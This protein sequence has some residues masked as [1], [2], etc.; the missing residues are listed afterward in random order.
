MIY[1]DPFPME[2]A[3]QKLQN[4]CGYQERCQKDV[5][6]KLIEIGVAQGYIDA[7]IDRLI[8]DDFL[9]EERFARAFVRGKFNIKK[10]GKIR[11][12]AELKK[13]QI[14]K[15]HLDL[16]LTQ[17][18]ETEY[19]ETFNELAEKK[20]QSIMDTDKRKG[21]KKL[22]DYLLYRGWES[23]LVYEKTWELIP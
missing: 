13:R 5:H 10:W 7:I 23:N 21:R 14:S 12:K 16:A 8:K 1:K 17:I 22:I 15:D 6:Q 4:Y 3:L 11:L 20:C 19:L 9:N 2:K 18:T